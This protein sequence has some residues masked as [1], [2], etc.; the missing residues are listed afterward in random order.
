[1]TETFDGD[2]FRRIMGCVPTP[3]T[4]VTAMDG[5]DP[6]AMVIGSFGSVSLDPPLVMFMPGISSS[7]WPRIE[8]AGS[9]CVNVM[10]DDQLDTCNAFFTKE[11]DPFTVNEW[12]TAGSGSPRLVGAAA[13]IDCD[14]D[15]VVVAGDH[16]IV[17]GRVLELD[18]DPQRL[19]LVFH[20]GG[21]GTFRAL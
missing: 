14:I 10:G 16:Y 6:V 13:W 1:M 4:V 21:Y 17:I 11:V 19:P 7:T 15:Q 20:G 8:V 9:F 5:D 18:G 3:V 2:Q 12:D